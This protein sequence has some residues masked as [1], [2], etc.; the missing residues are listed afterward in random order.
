MTDFKPGDRVCALSDTKTEGTVILAPPS[1]DF[2]AIKWDTGFEN[3]RVHKREVRRVIPDV[4]TIPRAELPEVV[5]KGDWVTFEETGHYVCGIRAS[6]AE[7]APALRRQ[8]F[9]LLAAI[10]YL[11][12]REKEA[13]A[14]R[15]KAEQEAADQ[16]AA[17]LN[18][19]RDELAAELAPRCDSNL[20]PNWY[21]NVSNNLQRAIDRIIQLESAVK[22]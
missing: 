11:E 9:E 12:A 16:H 7:V 1:P 18:K 13:D 6:A 2:I 14:A 10:D 20:P 21:E 15:E 8:A 4:L 19:R 5:I 22:K 3:Y 17:I